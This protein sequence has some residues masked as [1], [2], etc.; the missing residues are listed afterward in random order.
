MSDAVIKKVIEQLKAL[1]EN[2]QEE[3]LRLLEALTNSKPIG[4]S[5]ESLLK[6]AGIISSDDLA[7][8]QLV[9]SAGCEQVD[10]DEW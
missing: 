1:S 8:M 5:G 10:L 4:V 9:I 6:F 7:K 2:L 3:F